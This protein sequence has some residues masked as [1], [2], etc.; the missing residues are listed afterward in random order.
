LR[1]PEIP[2]MEMEIDPELVERYIVN[3]LRRYVFES[4]KRGGVVGVSG[5]IDSAT[6][7]FLVA[8]ALGE[9]RSY[10]YI[11][12]SEATS[13]EDLRDAM[14]VVE[15]LRIPEE[16]FGVIPVDEIVAGFEKAVGE[17]DRVARG[18]IRA[19]TRMVILYAKASQ[20][21]ALVIGT[22]DKSE[23]TI[24]YFTKYGDAGA[25]VLPIGDLFKTQVRRLAEYLGVPRQII[26]KP[27]TPALWRGQTAEEEIGVGYP[28]LDTILFYRFDKRLSDEETAERAGVDIETV[29]MIVN[30]VK[31]TQ[32]KRQ[33][34]EIFGIS[35]SHGSDWR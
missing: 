7:A 31:S 32:H 5:G 10:C 21:N 28:L 29:R 15:L 4:G 12:P 24:G 13:E 2:P 1:R 26:E 35:Y 18:N 25:D 16:N 20:N 23:I 27:P 8:R 9:E 17:V 30:M 11:L 33:M 3:R 6:T 34:P 19:R 14:Q 22:G